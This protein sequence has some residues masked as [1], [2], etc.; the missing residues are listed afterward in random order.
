MGD[1]ILRDYKETYITG[2]EPIGP[3]AEGIYRI[4]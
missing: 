3:H 2:N 1:L 4:T